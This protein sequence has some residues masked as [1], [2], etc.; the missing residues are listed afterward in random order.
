MTP[1]AYRKNITRKRLAVTEY[2]NISHPVLAKNYPAMP[3][4]DELSGRKYRCKPWTRGVIGAEKKT[5]SGLIYRG[6]RRNASTMVT[7]PILISDSPEV[8]SITVTTPEPSV[9]T[10]YRDPQDR[11]PTYVIPWELTWEAN[12]IDGI[13]MFEDGVFC[14]RYTAWFVPVVWTTKKRD[15]FTLKMPDAVVDFDWR[16]RLEIDSDSEESWETKLSLSVTTPDTLGKI[17][18]TGSCPYQPPARVAPIAQ[19][20]IDRAPN[21]A[22]GSFCEPSGKTSTLLGAVSSRRSHFTRTTS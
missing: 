4:L 10:P 22:P 1:I 6:T 17:D 3:S 11:M 8:P 19:V 16:P 20:F 21:P 9:W 7:F 18:Y 5:Q 2:D 13:L 14:R 15:G 12:D